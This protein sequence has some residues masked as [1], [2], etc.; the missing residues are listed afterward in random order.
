MKNSISEIVKLELLT[1]LVTEGRIEDNKKKYPKDTEVVDY[2]VEQDPS[3]NNKYLNWMMKAYKQMPSESPTNLLIQGREFISKLI[4]GFHQHSAR[5]EKKDINQYKNLAELNRVMEP[6]IK[7]SEEKSKQKIEIEDGVKK[8]YEDADWL[9]VIPLTHKAS[10][11]YGAGTQWCTTAKDTAQHFNSYSKRGTLVYLIHKKTNIK[12]AVYGES[13]GSNDPFNY[14]EIYNPNDADISMDTGETITTFIEQIIDGNVQSY[15][16]ED[17]GDDED[18][19]WIL[20]RI[21][22][23]NN[24]YVL[25]EYVDDYYDFIYSTVH[26]ILFNHFFG[27]GSGR[28]TLE[29]YK[30]VLNIFGLTLTLDKAKRGQPIH[31]NI[32]DNSTSEVFYN[33]YNKDWR[34]MDRSDISNII[35]EYIAELV[36]ADNYLMSIIKNNNLP[37]VIEGPGYNVTPDKETPTYDNIMTNEQG[38]NILNAF[39][40]ITSDFIGNTIENISEVVLEYVNR[41]TIE[42]GILRI[43]EKCINKP[44]FINCYSSNR[45][46]TIYP[47]IWNS[48]LLLKSEKNRNLKRRFIQL[49]TEIDKKIGSRLNSDILFNEL[50]KKYLELKPIKK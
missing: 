1:T 24:V 10:C 36:D 26:Y 35:S 23:N 18:D 32:I 45:K 44:S 47:D 37:F 4:K 22:G 49:K 43:G 50:F 3:G 48:P 38:R 42:N 31:F 13:E 12:F 46:G 29:K 21:R 15:L 25:S 7:D 17:E 20:Y 14:L 8:Y 6:I 39:E 16:D 34:I 27:T 33:G 5:L 40:K 30:R 11:K 41:I 2:F 19:E 28:N 9:L